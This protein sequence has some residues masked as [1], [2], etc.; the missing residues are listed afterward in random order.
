MSFKCKYG[1]KPVKGTKLYNIWR[2]IK[3]RCNNPNDKAYFRYG[4]RGIYI[5]NLWENDYGSFLSWSLCNGYKEGLSIDR[6]DNDGPY[7]P[8]NCRW[9]SR[10][11]QQNNMRSNRYIEFGGERRTISGW[12]EY[13]GIKPQTLQLRLHK[14]TLERALT[15]PKHK[16][17]VRF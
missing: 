3:G 13:L 14:W 2:S 10:K 7:S 15:E 11:V 5:S 8:E 12:A 6:I 4:G 17:R 1:Q 16:E 9:V